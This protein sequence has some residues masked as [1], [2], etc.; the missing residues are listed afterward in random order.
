MRVLRNEGPSQPIFTKV[1]RSLRSFALEMRGQSTVE[2]LVVLVASLGMALALG[3]LWKL[4]AQGKLQELAAGAASH[5]AQ[6]LGGF[7]D[8]LLF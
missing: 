5:V 4:G 1:A 3:A 7:R 8:I 6:S 2:Y